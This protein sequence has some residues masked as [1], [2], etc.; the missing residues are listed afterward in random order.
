MCE[1]PEG[2]KEVGEVPGGGEL[3]LLPEKG[4]IVQ[5]LSYTLHLTPYTLYLVA[6]AGFC[7][8]LGG[9]R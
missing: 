9:G 7:L 2:G 6:C 3:G 4:L 5:I 8:D 1:V